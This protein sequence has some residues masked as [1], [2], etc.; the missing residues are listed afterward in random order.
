MGEGFEGLVEKAHPSSN[1]SPPRRGDYLILFLE[2]GQALFLIS[3]P[4]PKSWGCDPFP[5]ETKCQ[6][7]QKTNSPLQVR[8]LL[9]KTPDSPLPSFFPDH[10]APA[11]GGAISL[12]GN[13]DE[14]GNSREKE[15]LYPFSCWSEEW[16]E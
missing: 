14:R 15:D 13:W 4:P 7:A 12:V 8:A 6:W 16:E 2:L 10:L 5:G 9:T 1:P 3:P 11:T